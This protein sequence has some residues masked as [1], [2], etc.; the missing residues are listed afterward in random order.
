MNAKETIYKSIDV[1]QLNFG[2]PVTM[3]EALA[4][5]SPMEWSEDVL[6]GE[7]KVEIKTDNGDNED[8]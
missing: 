8:V 2:T 5:V 7:K 4:D 6:N 3:T 1:S